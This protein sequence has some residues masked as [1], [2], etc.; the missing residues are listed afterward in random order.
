M[1]N[2]YAIETGIIWAIT[3][4]CTDKKN[5][6]KIWRHFEH[7]SKNGKRSGADVFIVASSACKN[8]DHHVRIHCGKSFSRYQEKA[9][10][11]TI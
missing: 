10:S 4:L 8:C 11:T 2:W 3:V 9:V 7:L 6:F 1:Q 5:V